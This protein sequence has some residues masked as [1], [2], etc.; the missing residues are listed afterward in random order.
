MIYAFID[1]QRAA[2]RS[3]ES[4]CEVL[5]S[6][7][8]QAAARSYRRARAAGA[9]LAGQVLAL[10]YLANAIHA[11]AFRYESAT[12]TFRLTPAGLYGRR[13]MTALLR[14]QSHDVS[15]ERVHRAMRLLRHNGIRRGRMVRTTIPAKDGNRAQG[16]PPPP[17]RSRA[18]PSS[19]PGS[20][21][22]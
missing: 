11:L 12:G 6:V 13:M 8:I 10:A 2:G 18:P 20:P 16:L 22:P 21:P 1:H 5:T 4:V 14:R 15:R 3:V 9:V 17:V 7:G 19:R